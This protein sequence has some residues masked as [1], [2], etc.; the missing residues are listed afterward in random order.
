M[1]MKDTLK[2]F[3]ETGD[4]WERKETSL[5]GVSLIRLPRTKTRPA[6]LAVEINPV[7]EKGAGIK[8]K[9]IM[10]MGLAE[11]NA[12]QEVFSNEKLAVLLTAIE[13]VIPVKKIQKPEKSDILEI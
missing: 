5:P 8:K 1:D 4:D 9:G 6:S 2:S 12:F 11:L 13:D 10:I 7:N 3:L